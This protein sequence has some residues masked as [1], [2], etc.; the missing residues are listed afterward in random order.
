MQEEDKQEG[1]ENE[2]REWSRHG[3]RNR[4]WKWVPVSKLRSKHFGR[5][6]C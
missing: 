3:R 2:P 6:S 4:G 1:V 5:R